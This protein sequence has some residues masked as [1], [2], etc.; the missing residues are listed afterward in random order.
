LT[1]VDIKSLLKNNFL[2]SNDY[3]PSEIN[4]RC[5]FFNQTNRLEIE[6]NNRY[7]I[8]L[9]SKRYKNG[10]IKVYFHTS[11]SNINRDGRIDNIIYNLINKINLCESSIKF[12][13]ARLIEAENEIEPNVVLSSDQKQN[14]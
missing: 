3:Y 6:E 14:T 1:S 4:K 5:Y 12:T 9:D 8:S 11:I 2:S 13:K 7:L 10:F